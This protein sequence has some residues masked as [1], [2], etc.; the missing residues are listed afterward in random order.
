MLE[1]YALEEINR[2]STRVGKRIIP[3]VKG[4]RKEIYLTTPKQSICS[5]EYT[6]YLRILV[7]INR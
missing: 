2:I 5:I 3:S 1:A 4:K 6:E 7:N